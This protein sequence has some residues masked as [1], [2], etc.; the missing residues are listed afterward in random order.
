MFVDSEFAKREPMTHDIDEDTT[1]EIVDGV[2]TE[3]IDGELVVLDLDGDVYFSLNDVGRAIW[4]EAAG[5][6]SFAEIVDAVVSQY[7][8]ERGRARSD[9]ADFLAEVLDEGLAERC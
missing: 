1:F 6:G 7:D 8:V 3:E 5:G 9:A 4:E 2:L